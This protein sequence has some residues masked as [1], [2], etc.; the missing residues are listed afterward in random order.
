MLFR[1]VRAALCLQL[2]GGAELDVGIVIFGIVIVILKVYLTVILT[3]CN[4]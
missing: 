4:V 2:H 3:V 1:G